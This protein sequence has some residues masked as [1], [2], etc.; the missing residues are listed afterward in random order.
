[1]AI[2]YFL[3]ARKSTEDEE[4]QV[5]SIEA[6][7][8][9]LQEFAKRENIV[10][11]KTFIESKSAKKPGREIF[12][13]MMLEVEKSKES[14]GLLAWHPDRLARNSIDGGQIIYSIDTEKITSLKFPTF[15][16]EPTPQGLFMLQVAFG[17]S[18]YYSDNLSENVKRGIRQKLRRGE[19]PTK[20]PFGYINN[21]KTRNV[22]PDPFKSRIIKKTFEEFATGNHT[23]Q[24]LSDRLAFWGVVGSTG[25]PLVKA[26]I[27]HILTNKVYLGII[28]HKGETYEGTFPA[29][30]NS[31]TFEAAQ[32]ILQ[33]R[34]HP[35]KKKEG[36]HFPFT[37]L[38]TCAE[39]GA[40]VTA[41]FAHGHGGTYRYYRC[42]KRLGHCSQKYIS[43]SKLIEQVKEQLQTIS[44]SE[45]WYT[46]GLARIKQWEEASKNNHTN[47]ALNLDNKIQALD[48]K[49]SMLVDAFL[50]GTLD[51]QIYLKKKEELIKQKTDFNQKKSAFRRQGNFR[52]EP[53]K[54]FWK[55]LSLAKKLA[56]SNDFP[57]IKSFVAKN[58]TNP[59]LQTKTVSWIWT[60]A[61]Q[62]VEQFVK[63][64][65]HH[66]AN[67]SNKTAAPRSNRQ[68]SS[69]QSAAPRRDFFGGDAFEN[70][71][72]LI[73]SG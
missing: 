2:Q 54:E 30:V 9:E 34:S 33:L 57:E 19:W 20:A 64:A 42:T 38:F 11:A 48:Q 1:M 6:Q 35:R 12:N 23:F 49:L 52:F 66:L 65:A 46:Q 60:G 3:Y 73:K 22:E 27:H 21:P 36:H 40:S 62:I 14:V 43:E 63:S 68:A 61:F 53:L 4:R 71:L 41:Q 56:V 10:I 39:C 29:L 15:W 44:L 16:F 26:A 17:Q 24:T 7:L 8:T 37:G 18:K 70:A 69:G 45:E 50:D 58:G 72:C 13:E 28:S 25:K 32:K 47:F 55:D 5:M 51:K 59:Q 31:T 67:Q